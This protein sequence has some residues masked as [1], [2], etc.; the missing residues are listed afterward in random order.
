M[1]ETLGVMNVPLSWGERQSLH[2]EDQAG[3]ILGLSPPD[4][5][6]WGHLGARRHHIDGSPGRN[7]TCFQVEMLSFPCQAQPRQAEVCLQEWQGTSTS[8]AARDKGWLGS[9]EGKTAAWPLPDSSIPQLLQELNGS[10]QRLL[11]IPSGDS[12]K[13][14][15]LSVLVALPGTWVRV[16]QTTQASVFSS[17]KR[18]F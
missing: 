5:L 9:E 16:T 12:I 10:W 17:I 14:R 6:L 4:N 7:Y 18:G 1:L 8:S 3:S 13:A 11:G 2:W 15:L